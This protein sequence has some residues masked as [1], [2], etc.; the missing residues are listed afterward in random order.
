MM[1]IMVINEISF[2]ELN[3]IKIII[4]YSFMSLLGYT[5]LLLIFI[6]FFTIFGYRMFG[7]KHY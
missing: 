7:N 2:S 3:K 5:I 6:V 4:K 1:M